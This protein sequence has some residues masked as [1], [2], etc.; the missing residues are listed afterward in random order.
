MSM[1]FDRFLI[2]AA[3]PAVAVSFTSIAVFPL[4]IKSISLPVLR[5]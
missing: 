3:S 1:F 4:R 2:W 5:E